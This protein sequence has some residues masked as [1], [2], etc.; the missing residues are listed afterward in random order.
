[1]YFRHLKVS[2]ILIFDNP[3]FHLCTLNSQKETISSQYLIKLKPQPASRHFELF[4]VSNMTESFPH[5][6]MT[7]L[8]KEQARLTFLKK[9]MHAIFHEINGNFFFL[10]TRLFMYTRLLGRSF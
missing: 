8:I 5:S 10:L 9:K 4:Q 1:M 6:T 2:P 3:S 7:C